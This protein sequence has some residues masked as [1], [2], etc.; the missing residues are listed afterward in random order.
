VT[1]V[2]ALAGVGGCAVEQGGDRVVPAETTTVE[3][4][5]TQSVFTQTWNGMGA[6]M[7][8]GSPDG[9]Y[10]WVSVFEGGTAQNRTTTLWYALHAPDPTSVECDVWPWPGCSYTRYTLEYGF[11]AISP[12]D[13]TSNAGGG[14]ARVVTTLP[15]TF[16][17]TRC[18]SD[19][20][21]GSYECG[22]GTAAGTI[23]LAWTD[24]NVSSMLQSGTQQQTFG[25][26]MF[27]T[28]GTYRGSSADVA[29]TLLGL[30]IDVT[31]MAGTISSTRGLNVTKSITPVP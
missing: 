23:D 10:G 25:R 30:D 29:G 27:K 14:W 8:F 9:S 17:S 24:N 11:G 12:A 20:S 2:A 22:P 3:Q 5:S 21:T 19:T 4:A 26:T 13:F 15:A 6:D 18:T 1:V 16:E 7:S 31:G 28:Q